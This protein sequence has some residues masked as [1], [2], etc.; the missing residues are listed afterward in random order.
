MFIVMADQQLYSSHFFLLAIAVFLLTLADPGSQRSVDSLRNRARQTSPA[1]PLL[2]LKVQL[3]IVY[4]FAAFAKINGQF[5]SGD[6]MTSV[7]EG[8]ALPLVPDASRHDAIVL[9]SIATVIGEFAIAIG[10]WS[11][12]TRRPALLMTIA[13]H[14]SIPFL[15]RPSSRYELTEFG[16]LMITLYS[17]FV[18]LPIGVIARSAGDRAAFAQPNDPSEE[19]TYLGRTGL[20]TAQGIW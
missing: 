15:M 16:L 8:R 11:A 19:P 6:K 3:T 9:L 12:R 18:V 13:L 17:L 7:L 4:L 2:M 14:V 20:E 10:I 1:W 5:L